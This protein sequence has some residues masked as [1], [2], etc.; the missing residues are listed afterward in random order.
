MKVLV[1]FPSLKRVEKA[2]KCIESIQTA[3][4]ECIGDDIFVRVVFNDPNE[5][6]AIGNRFGEDASLICYNI[7]DEHVAPK[8]WNDLLLSERYD[9]LCYLSDDLE[10][11]KNCLKNGINCMKENFP[12]F[13]GVVGL[14]M[15]NCPPGQVVQA[16]FG[17][18]GRKFAERFIDKQVF[19]PEYKKFCIDKE[20]EMFSKSINR[21]VYCEEATLVHHHPAFTKTPPDHTHQFVRTFLQLDLAIFEERQKRGYLWGSTF[22]KIGAVQ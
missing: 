13:D 1:A 12:D 19:C 2:I 22:E 10:L 14:K 7:K 11:D 15:S 4:Q 20:L 8:M 16:A 5:A 21:F 6:N 18:I 3:A 17:M 9:I